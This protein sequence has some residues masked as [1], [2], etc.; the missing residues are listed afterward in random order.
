MDLSLSDDQQSIVEGFDRFLERECTPERVRAAEPLGFDA[1]LWKQL[2]EMGLTTLAL[3]EDAGGG[4]F[5]LLDAALVTESAGARLVPA[6]FVEAA[7]AVRAVV[8]AGQSVPADGLVTF[9]LHPAV[10]GVARLVPGGAVAV[11]VEGDDGV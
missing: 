10:D 3:P 5:G 1:D 11:A 2:T 4:A 6:P 7:V 9:A 8:R